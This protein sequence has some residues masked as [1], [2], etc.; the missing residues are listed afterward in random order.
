MKIGFR[1][2]AGENVGL[3]H[4]VRSLALAQELKSRGAHC[5][6]RGNHLAQM[7]ATRASFPVISDN[8]HAL[9]RA[10]AWIVDMQGGCSPSIAQ[11]FRWSC[12]KLVILN[13][14]GYSPDDPA[15]FLADLVFY[16]GCSERPRQLD[17]ARFEGQWY[18]GAEWI[19]LRPEFGEYRRHRPSGDLAH[20][21]RVLISGGGMNKGSVAN[22]ILDALSGC[23]YQMRVI[24]GKRDDGL[25]KLLRQKGVELMEQPLNVAEA[26]DWADVAVIAYGMTAFECLCLGL[27]VVALSLTEGHAEGAFIVNSKSYGALSNLRLA[28]EI[29]EHG[30]QEAVFDAIMHLGEMSQSALDF[31]DGFGVQRVADRILEELGCL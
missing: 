3:G 13:G 10:D 28:S 23:N 27:P 9:M 2:D 14:V 26:M 24:S 31:V 30:I 7:F 8:E 19:I 6:F 15:R 5:W 25:H 18:E 11:R 21:P 29:D 12:E 17:W 20:L 22:K 16:Q 1:V 4:I